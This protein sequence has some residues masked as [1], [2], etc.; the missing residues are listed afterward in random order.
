ML[1]A[2]LPASGP[3]SHTVVT[4]CA[5]LPPM[6]LARLV[7]D[8]REQYFRFDLEAASKVREG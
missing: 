7:E 4:C 1:P 3:A 5:A 8:S 6:Q 2:V